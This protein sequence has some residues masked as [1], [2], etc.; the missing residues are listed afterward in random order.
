MCIYRDL[1]IQA[2]TDGDLVLRYPI[3]VMEGLNHASF[4]STEL[5]GDIQAL[6]IDAEIPRDVGHRSI[7]N[8][9]VL[10]MTSALK[11]TI[12]GKIDV[13]RHLQL[14]YSSTFTLLLVCIR[15]SL[16]MEHSN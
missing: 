9:T 2:R 4:L 3:V 1:I 12:G 7:A 11:L 15:L 13:R 14:A 16:K 8:Y 6:D 10:F 5:D